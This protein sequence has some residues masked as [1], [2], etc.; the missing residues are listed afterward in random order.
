M[1]PINWK[2][3][4]RFMTSRSGGKG[5]QNV[6]KVETQVEAH[7]PIVNNPDFSPGQIDLLQKN[8]SSKLTKEGIL[9]VKAQVHRSQHANKWEAEQKL[10]KLLINSLK[11]K[12]TRIATKPSV[13]SKERKLESKKKRST[14]KAERRKFRLDD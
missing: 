13:A 2:D 6:N 12:K 3:N 14:V 5:G 4:I 7:L 8:L 1:L 11:K 9:I 10:E